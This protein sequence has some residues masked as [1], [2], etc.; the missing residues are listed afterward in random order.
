MTRPKKR[1]APLTREELLGAAVGI[2]DKQGLGALTMRRLAEEV[3]VEA[4]SLY[5]HVP[6]KDALLDGVIERIITEMRGPKPPYDDWMA[7]METMIGELRRVL[8]EHPNVLPLLA[9]RPPMTSAATPYVSVPLRMLSETGMPAEDVVDLYQSL[10]AFTFGH[11][12]LSAKLPD[13]VQMSEESAGE[14]TER[15]AE[16]DARAFSRTVRMILEGYGRSATR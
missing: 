11:S 14:L 16:W 3:G 9:V 4:M 2:V 6:N 12:L 15:M 10:L 13:R 8:L 7:T 5:H 1:T